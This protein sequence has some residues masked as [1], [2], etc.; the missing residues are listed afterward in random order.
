MCVCE[1]LYI[2]ANTIVFFFFEYVIGAD[3]I[4]I[5]EKKQVCMFSAFG[6]LEYIAF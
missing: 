1:C 2:F 4:N 6:L 3:N 5:R